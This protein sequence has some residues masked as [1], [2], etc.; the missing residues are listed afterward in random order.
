M[1]LSELMSEEVVKI[2]LVS[3]TKPAVLRE[4]VEFLEASG[5]L[6][7]ADRVYDDLLEREGLGS[8]G[9]ELG[10]AVPHCRT[11]AVR[12]LVVA[13]GVSPEGI[14]FAAFDGQRCHLFFLVLA[15]ID[16]PSSHIQVLAEIGSITQSA[17]S[18]RGLISAQSAREFMLRLRQ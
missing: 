15:P 7:D 16:R 12:E 10:V 5:R 14:D 17:E 13:A 2:P 3:G 8:T 11:A 4:F 18:I 9:L 6:H 1:D